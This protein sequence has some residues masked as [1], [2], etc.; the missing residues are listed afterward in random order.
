MNIYPCKYGQE[1][2]LS[3]MLVYESAFSFKNNST[4]F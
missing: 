3:N 1:I 4:G 2:K